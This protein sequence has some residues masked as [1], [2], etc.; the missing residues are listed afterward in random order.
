MTIQF[1]KRPSA[2]A[3]SHVELGVAAQVVAGVVL[4]DEVLGHGLQADE[5]VPLAGHHLLAGVQGLAGARH[6]RLLVA[7]QRDVVLD[8]G[9]G[10]RP[11]RVLAGVRLGARRLPV[12]A[13][14]VAQRGRGGAV[15]VLLGRRPEVAGEGGDG[16]HGRDGVER[17][18][19]AREDR[20]AVAGLVAHLPGD[21]RHGDEVRQ[22]QAAE[23]GADLV[24]RL[25]GDVLGVDLGD[26]RDQVRVLVV[27]R[28]LAQRLERHRQ[29]RDV[30]R[31]PDVHEL[32][33]LL[34]DASRTRG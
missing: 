29:R 21:R 9:V 23:V 11:G 10:E 18:A 4:D 8:L 16:V 26:R 5:V 27:G 6:D 20:L 3:S 7:L 17:L 32:A 12:R 2:R 34:V 33:G 14:V 22:A 1:Q 28:R 13:A 19:A 31:V 30:A 15:H 25:L 24:V